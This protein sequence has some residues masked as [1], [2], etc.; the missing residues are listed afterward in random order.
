M[1]Y[2]DLVGLVDH[3]GRYSSHITYHHVDQVTLASLT[4]I[5]ASFITL[6]SSIEA[7]YQAHGAASELLLPSLKDLLEPIKI[8]TQQWMQE[9]SKT[10]FGASHL[11]QKYEKIADIEQQV[12]DLIQN[13]E[14]MVGLSSEEGLLSY[15]WSQ[16]NFYT[17]FQACLGDFEMSKYAH[18]L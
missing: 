9:I 16:I 15:L 2:F 12:G 5:E 3:E 18:T 8:P 11:E 7:C 17:L 10:S 14:T 1:R 6:V 4:S 13:L